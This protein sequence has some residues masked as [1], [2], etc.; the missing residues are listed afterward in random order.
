MLQDVYALNY[1][2]DTFKVCDS[3]VSFFGFSAEAE[4]ENVPDQRRTGYT[5]LA[6][7]VFLAFN[8]KFQNISAHSK[9]AARVFNGQTERFSQLF[10]LILFFFVCVLGKVKLAAAAVK[11]SGRKLKAAASACL[12]I[13]TT[14]NASRARARHF[15][16]VDRHSLQRR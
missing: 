12:V 3:R 1:R 15:S 6:E 9:V 4:L 10:L 2:K 14:R 11:Y 16:N 8:N 7:K 5:A 13:L